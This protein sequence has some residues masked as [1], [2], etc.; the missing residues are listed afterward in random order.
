MLWLMFPAYNEKKNL[1]KLLP[2]LHSFLKDKIEAYKILLIDDGSTDSTKELK[3]YSNMPVDLQ[4]ISH[5]KNK[6]IGEVFKTG[7]SAL[8]ALTG[9][10]DL[11]IIM[12]ADGTSDYTR[13]PLLVDRLRAGSDIVI[14]S[15]YM[16]GGA[17]RNFPLK[18]H[19]ISLVG[20]AILRI[21]FKVKNIEDYTIFYRGYKV[22]L[23]REALTKYGDGFIKS[24]TFLANTE[25]LLNL[26]KLTDKISEV[27]L[28][29]SYDLKI[30]K[31]KMPVMKTLCDYIKFLIINCFSLPPQP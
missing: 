6:G 3:G 24:K 8:S 21:V 15:R 1:V 27:P 25:A 12:E 30:G 19:L 11:L 10:N 9:E 26:A 28:V 14:A 20:N 23:I 17:Y 29:Y 2:E 13:I 31:S 5:E 7:F 18:R 4:I 16:P 22:K